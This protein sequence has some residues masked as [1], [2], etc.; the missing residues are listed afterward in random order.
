MTTRRRTPARTIVSRR[1][2]RWLAMMLLAICALAT[3]AIRAQVG[4]PMTGGSDAPPNFDIRTYKEDPRTADD[5]AAA[6]F[7]AQL[8]PPGATA[9]ALAASRVAALARL[10]GALPNVA[11]DVNSALRIP[12][13][14]SARPGGGFLTRAT[15]RPTASRRATRR[16]SS[17][18]PIT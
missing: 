4:A 13:V 14:V 6:A 5:T 16:A 1:G 7:L 3:A 12:E 17:S 18:W 2:Q 15:L 8:P 9:R 10:T 11:V